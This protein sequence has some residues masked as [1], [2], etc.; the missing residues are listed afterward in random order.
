MS[1]SRD[2]DSAIGEEARGI[3]KRIRTVSMKNDD[4][5]AESERIAKLRSI[6]DEARQREDDEYREAI[7]EVERARKR[8][9]DAKEKFQT[10]RNEANATKRSV[11][12]AEMEL[13]VRKR[14]L[15]DLRAEVKNLAVAELAAQEELKVMEEQAKEK[16]AEVEQ[17]EAEEKDTKLKEMQLEKYK[18]ILREK[19]AVVRER[20]EA[21]NKVMHEN[22]GMLDEFDD[23][24]IAA[25]SSNRRNISASFIAPKNMSSSDEVWDDDEKQLLER[26]KRVIS[27]SDEDSVSKW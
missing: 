3:R 15:L 26:A 5:E 24:A 6:N 2:G 10:T 9:E 27:M 25:R 13:E 21:L 22:R 4:L 7:D 19:T 1:F 18:K 23:C 14:H 20:R 11:E 12:T 8:L 17:V 16:T